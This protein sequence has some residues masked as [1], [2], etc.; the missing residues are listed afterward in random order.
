MKTTL[1]SAVVACLLSLSANAQNALTR[2]EVYE[3]NCKAIVQIYVEGHFSGVGFIASPDGIVM[4]ANH[5]VATRESS[6]KEYAGNIAVAVFGKPTPYPA[7]PISARVSDD[8]ANYDSAA[9][10]IAATGLPHVTLGSWTEVDIGDPITIIPSFPG[11][12]CILLEGTIAVKGAAQ[13]PLGPKPVNT[14]LFQSPIRNGFSGSPIFDS[15]GRVVGIE[16]TKVFGISQTLDD[17]RK[18]WEANKSPTA[19]V[20]VTVN[21]GQADLGATMLELINNLDQNLISGLGSG[22]AIEYS[23]KGNGAAEQ[24]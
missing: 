1:A 15:K 23:N 7:T 21:F 11:F 24:K 12:G 6:F 2:K 5:V 17:Q 9:V 19:P 10:R 14:I 3:I 20:T 13:T 8:Q 22:V 16:D 4:T 18:K